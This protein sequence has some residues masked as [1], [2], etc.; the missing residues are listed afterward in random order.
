MK[1]DLESLEAR[2]DVLVPCQRAHRRHKDAGGGGRCGGGSRRECVQPSTTGTNRRRKAGRGGGGENAAP[3]SVKI[4]PKRKFDPTT[5]GAA[6]R[7]A[8]GREGE[9]RPP[10]SSLRASLRSS[11]ARS[12]SPSPMR[13]MPRR[14]SAW[15]APERASCVQWRRLVVARG[16][17]GV[18]SGWGRCRAGAR[19]GAAGPHL[20]L[21][22]VLEPVLQ[23]TRRVRLVRG[24]GR[25]V[26]T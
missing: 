16:S 18:R 2:A 8:A 7:G 21:V 10:G 11:R 19:G 12:R 3:P 1:M 23:G 20:G 9:R 17:A 6:V 4:T 22:G 14:Y 25:G 5:A 15:G 26:S 13:A 24:E